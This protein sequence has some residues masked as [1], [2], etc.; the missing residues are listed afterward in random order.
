MCSISI[1]T[2]LNVLSGSFRLFLLGEETRVRFRHLWDD[3][4]Y[5]R[6]R[7]LRHYLIPAPRLIPAGA[8]TKGT[9]LPRSFQGDIATSWFS[10]QISLLLF[11][12]LAFPQLKVFCI[13]FLT[14]ILHSGPKLSWSIWFNF[15][16]SLSITP[17]GSHCSADYQ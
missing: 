10:C 5:I 15:C 9:L 7:T 16:S 4:H 13:G 6:N 1:S 12:Y 2:V 11:V 14:P 3:Q 17:G 8:S